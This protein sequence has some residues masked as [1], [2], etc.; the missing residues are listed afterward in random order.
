MLRDDKAQWFSEYVRRELGSMIYGSD[1]I[2]TSGFTVNT[3]LDLEHQQAAQD[4]MTKYIEIA[5]TRYQREHNSRSKLAYNT[6]I[7]MTE[8]LA[9]VFNLPQLKVSEQRTEFIANQAYINNVN[10]VLDV[11]SMM[12]GVDQLK[13]GIINRA[14]AISKKNEEKTTIEGTMICLGANT[15]YIDALV[16]GSKYDQ[17]NQFIRGFCFD[18]CKHCSCRTQSIAGS[19]EVR[20]RQEHRRAS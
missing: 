1:D 5:N 16:G 20:H 8:L 6:Y 10:P 13:V 12:T 2:Y 11:V 9:L 19:C 15:G 14:T 17:E 7:P 4:V 3:T 18:S